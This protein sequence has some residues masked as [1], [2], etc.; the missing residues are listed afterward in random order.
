M[1]VLKVHYWSIS[2]SQITEE[3]VQFGAQ[4]I[5]MLAVSQTIKFQSTWTKHAL[6]TENLKSFRAREQNTFEWCQEPCQFR[7]ITD[8]V[9]LPKVTRNQTKPLPV[10]L[11]RKHT[12][13]MKMVVGVWGI[14]LHYDNK[15]WHRLTLFIPMKSR[16]TSHSNTLFMVF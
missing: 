16:N 15:D 3:L 9:S 1:E 7:D 5:S 8:K 10:S 14:S 12:G 4:Q 6:C 11:K 2:L 13:W